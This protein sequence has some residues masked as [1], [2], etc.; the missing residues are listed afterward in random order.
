MTGNL[1]FRRGLKTNLPTSAPSGMP[2][3]CTDTKEL[4][5]GTETGVQKVGSDGTSGGTS[6]AVVTEKSVNTLAGSGTINLADNSVNVMA[7]T[8]AVEFVLPEI[9]DNTVFHEILV[10]VSMDSVVSFDLGTN[11]FL[12]S[13]EPD[14]SSAGIYNILFEFHED[15]WFAGVVKK[16]GV[17]GEKCLKIDFGTC[18][19]YFE[20]TINDGEDSASGQSS[21]K[22]EY[23]LYYPKGTTIEY[24]IS[25]YAEDATEETTVTDTITLDNNTKLYVPDLKPANE[26]VIDDSTLGDLLG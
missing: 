6:A 9:T 24:T 21:R 20:L 1:Q 26:G 4:F 15:T 16:N 19:G 7:A 25:Y 17:L 22:T 2:L 5:I 10:Q 13:D 18:T 11:K 3:W 12:T 23:T 8:G 14:M